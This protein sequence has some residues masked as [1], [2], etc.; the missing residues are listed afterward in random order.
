MVPPSSFVSDIDKLCRPELQVP[1]GPEVLADMSVIAADVRGDELGLL[2]YTSDVGGGAVC[3]KGV[4]GGPPNV[5]SSW[6]AD[7]GQNFVA[8]LEATQLCLWFNKGDTSG[9]QRST[10]HA[11][12]GRHGQDI[13]SVVIEETVQGRVEATTVDGWF[14]AWWPGEEQGPTRF[15]IVGLDGLGQPVTDL[16]AARDAEEEDWP[17]SPD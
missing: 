15:R 16:V 8:D 1:G 4:E 11:V 10:H 13:A 6:A 14:L 9:G 2:I 3:W 5:M 17:C 12:A 7:F